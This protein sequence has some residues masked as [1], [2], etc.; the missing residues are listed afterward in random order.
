MK[1][2]AY[3]FTAILLIF[4]ACSDEEKM[5]LR[6]DTGN[7][8]KVTV[9]F[10]LSMTDIQH[11]TEYIPM[12][13][14]MEET[15][16]KTDNLYSAIL[17]KKFENYWVI[18]SLLSLQLTN[19]SKYAR[20]NLTESSQLNPISL[21]LRPGDYHL[22]VII[23]PN[24][25]NWEPY[26]FEGSIIQ[27]DEEN[28]QALCGYRTGTESY[29]INGRLYLGAEIF[30]G[31]TSFT[32]KKQE[33][34]HGQPQAPFGTIDLIRRVGRFRVALLDDPSAGD[35]NFGTFGMEHQIV[36]EM[37]ATN[38]VF[39]NGL[40]LWGNP[41]YDESNP[42]ERMMYCGITQNTS[43][44]ANNSESYFLPYSGGRVFAIHFFTKPGRDVE[45]TMND[46]D[47][48][49]Q[50]NNQ[51]HHYFDD[52]PGLMIQDNKINGIILRAGDNVEGDNLLIDLIVVTDENGK[53][54]SSV[55]LLSP[56]AEYL[57]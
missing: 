41:Y 24:F 21:T 56:S 48:T 6:T 20:L 31:H 46:I 1:Q 7:D 57:Q 17:F 4:T 35:R 37:T 27:I 44:L 45:F 10:G 36:S 16:V 53:P 11:S 47:I 38:D 25:I 34:L 33:D 13:A 28:P 5:S 30:S 43:L 9:T 19:D 23:N 54:A 42:I 8:E 40:D 39:C 18:D 50:S 51:Y 2:L 3:I 14:A 32:I 55:P 26:I 49:F 29:A 15:V 52:I 12:R 22:T